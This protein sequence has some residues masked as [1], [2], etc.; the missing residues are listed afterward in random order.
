MVLVRRPYPPRPLSA[1]ARRLQLMRACGSELARLRRVT[2]A[3]AAKGDILAAKEG[4]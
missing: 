3:A 1:V 2:A 4:R